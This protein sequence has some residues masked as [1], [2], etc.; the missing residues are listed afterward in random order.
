MVRAAEPRFQKL[1]I[2]IGQLP[3]LG[4]LKDGNALSQKELAR[5]ANIEQPTMAQLLARME[6]DGLIQRA[7]DPADKRSSLISLTAK[8]RRKLPRAH[9]ELLRSGD[10][11]FHAFSEREIATLSRLLRKLILSLDPDANLPEMPE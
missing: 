7:P 5:R 2:S 11:A 6:R 8:A 1:G 4:A 10:E 9:E 3:V